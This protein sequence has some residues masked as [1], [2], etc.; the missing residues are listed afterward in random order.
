MRIDPAPGP[1]TS[2]HARCGEPSLA[3]NASLGVA[4]KIVL[5]K[6]KVYTLTL[7]GTQRRGNGRRL[8]SPGPA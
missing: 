8:E 3:A 6:A 5:P 1:C 7:A 4:D 2:N